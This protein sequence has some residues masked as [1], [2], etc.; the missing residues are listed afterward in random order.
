[1]KMETHIGDRRIGQV[2]ADEMGPPGPGFV[3][4][5]RRR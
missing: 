4:D 5:V 1:M 2:D 3:A